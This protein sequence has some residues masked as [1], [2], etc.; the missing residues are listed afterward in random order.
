MATSQAPPKGSVMS[1]LDLALLYKALLLAFVP[2]FLARGP[3]AT[4]ALLQ[5]HRDAYQRE[6]LWAGD[7]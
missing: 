6:G 4:L 2:F 5:N 3:G 7:N 1:F